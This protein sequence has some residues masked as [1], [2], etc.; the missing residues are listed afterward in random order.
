MIHSRLS[1]SQRAVK[2]EKGEVQ[3]AY[4]HWFSL[5]SGRRVRTAFR[6]SRG[7]TLTSA[8]RCAQISVTESERIGGFFRPHFARLELNQHP[9]TSSVL[10]LRCSRKRRSNPRIPP[11]ELGDEFI[12]SL[13]TAGPGG[14]LNTS[15]ATILDFHSPANIEC[16]QRFRSCA[17]AVS[18]FRLTP[19]FVV[20]LFR[21]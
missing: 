4:G 3:E 1:E 10:I 12:H 20:G 14:F 16:V 9:G 18:I 15:N 11:T 17:S 21:N 5:V 8:G 6:N 7:S 19:L 2:G 13:Q